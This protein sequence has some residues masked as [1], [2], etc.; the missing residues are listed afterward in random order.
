MIWLQLKIIES[1]NEALSSIPEIPKNEVAF[2]EKNPIAMGSYSEVFLCRWSQQRV[3]VKKLRI[4]QKSEQMKSL[5]LE[6]SLAISLFHPNIVRIFGCLKMDN[7]FL[8]IVMEW[9]N[10]GSLKDKIPSLSY[11]QKVGVA[12]CICDGVSYLHSKKIAHRDLKPDNV[13][14]F[15]SEPVAKISDFGTSKVWRVLHVLNVN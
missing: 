14:L 8:G 7:G 10:Q 2:I 3:A 6:T 9:A 12:L 4:T 15:G 13:L 1:R 11:S 5:K